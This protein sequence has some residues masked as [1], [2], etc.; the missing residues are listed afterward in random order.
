MLVLPVQPVT[1]TEPAG[2]EEVIVDMALEAVQAKFADQSFRFQLSPRWIPRSVR[3]ISPAQIQ[4]VQPVGPIQKYTSFEVVYQ[5]GGQ[6]DKTEIQLEV[7]AEQK[8]PVLSQRVVAGQAIKAEDLSWAWIQ[9]TLGREQPV[10]DMDQLLGKTLRRTL[11]PGQY[12][13][14]DYLSA[15]YVVEAGGTVNLVYQQ[16]GLQIMLA[17]EARQD[18]ALND[19]IQIYCKETRNKYL[20]KI[21]GPGEAAWLRTH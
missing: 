13:N 4:M 12:I 6:P 15:G 21:T 19:E 20:G 8:L 16:N 3:E 5:A 1:A 18:G 10:S 2:A 11:N 17:C 7:V 14:P 9:I